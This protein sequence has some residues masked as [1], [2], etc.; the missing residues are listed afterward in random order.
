MQTRSSIVECYRNADE[1]TQCEMWL[2]YRDLRKQFEAVELP[3]SAGD[4]SSA[5]SGIYRGESRR[6][7][8]RPHLLSR[9]YRNCRRL[10]GTKAISSP[11]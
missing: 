5:G 6:E 2:A 3:V 7:D 10:C 11:T 9:I 8:D 4:M 1:E